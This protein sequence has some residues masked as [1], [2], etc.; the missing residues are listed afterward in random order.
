MIFNRSKLAATSL[1]LFLVSLFSS[2]SAHAQNFNAYDLIAAV[3]N[4]RANQGLSP[5]E[6]DAWLMDYAQQ[7]SNY[8]ASINSSTH[9][10]KDGSNS[11]SIGV[12]ENIAGGTAS[13]MTVDFI[14]NQIWA[15]AVHM[16]TMVGYSSG[17]VGAGDR[18]QRG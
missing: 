12:M 6:V 16:K 8:Q 17:T 7:H 13:L 11:L 15:D 10:H 14:V 3:N 4:L 18:Y 9:T 2:F 5:Y 1:G